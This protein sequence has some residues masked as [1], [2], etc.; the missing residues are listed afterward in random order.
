V[1]QKKQSPEKARG[2]TKSQKRKLK[3]FRRNEAPKRLGVQQNRGSGKLNVS[4]EMKP[5]TGQGFITQQN[6]KINAS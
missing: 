6:K 5:S 2:S 1:F 3:R 4:E